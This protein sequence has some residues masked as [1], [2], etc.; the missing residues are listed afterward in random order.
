M[1]EEAISPVGDSAK[2]ANPT[3]LFENDYDDNGGNIISILLSG[4]VVDGTMLS[5]ET[6][7]LMRRRPMSN[8]CS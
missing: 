7:G 4:A 2:P 1:L 8:A 3:L 5:T 6:E